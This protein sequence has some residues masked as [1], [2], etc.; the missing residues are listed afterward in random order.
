LQNVMVPSVQMLY[1]D[2]IIHLQQDHFRI[3]DSHMVQERLL[4]QASELIDCHCEHLTWTPSRI[5]GV[6]WKGQCR[7]PGLSS[8]PEITMSY[9]P[10]CQ[11]RVMKLLRL[12]VTVSHWLSPWHDNWNQWLKQKGSGLLIKEVN[13]WKQPFHFLC[14]SVILRRSQW[15]CKLWPLASW[16]CGFKS[17]Q[18]HGCLSFVSVVCCFSYI[19]K[20]SDSGTQTKIFCFWRLLLARAQ[21]P[22]LHKEICW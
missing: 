11:T 14:V 4:R 22:R 5:C 17:H 13:F 6:R 15:L 8:L 20:Y 21:L 9:G 3:N 19:K 1:P 18:G 7:K 12:S 2:G 10:L 16:D